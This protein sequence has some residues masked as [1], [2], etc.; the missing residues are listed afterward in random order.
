MKKTTFFIASALVTLSSLTASFSAVA[1]GSAYPSK[2]VKFIN[3]WPPGG[4]SDVLARSLAEHLQQSLKQPFV[5]ENRPGAGGNLGAD[6]V[7]KSAPDGHTVLIGIDTTFTI[8]P[9]IYKSM[10][11]KPN[12]LKPIAIIA[13]SGLL[14]GVNPATDIKTMNDLVAR[15]RGKGLTFSS[16]SNGSPGHLA[17]E[18]L[19][20]AAKVKVTHVP[21]KGNTPAVMAV[22]AGEVDGGALATPGM[23]PFVKANKMNALAVTSRKRSP[24][25]PEVPTVAE[26]GLKELSLEV[27]YVAM[28][29]AATPPE[30]VAVLQKG[31]VEALGRPDI[32]ARL[33]GLDLTIEAETGAAAAQRLEGLRN[34]YAPIIKSTGMQ[35]E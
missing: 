19:G 6:L 17:A 33:D 24:L 14:I 25:A 23:L 26:V 11:F 18:I 35:I 9:G 27:F 29:P 8:N 32:K 20:D 34:R 3:S 16:G 12:D 7:A 22:I 4:P 28:V 31:I 21:Y 30:V 15:G 1:Q 2:P 10:P 5:V 13:S